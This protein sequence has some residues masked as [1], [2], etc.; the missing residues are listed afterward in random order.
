MLRR[1]FNESTSRRVSPTGCGRKGAR[2]YSSPSASDLMKDP[3][4][5]PKL[6]TILFGKIMLLRIFFGNALLI[7][8]IFGFRHMDGAA[9]CKVRDDGYMDGGAQKSQYFL[10][11]TSLGGNSW[12]WGGWR[13]TLF[14][15][16]LQIRGPD[17]A[18]T[19]AHVVTM[20]VM[21]AQRRFKSGEGHG[22][23]VTSMQ[24][25]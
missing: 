20:E 8:Y 21:H 23:R 13:R 25:C 6:L 10:C 18:C 3:A 17:A 19:E 12:F 5:G 24:I 11:S 4:G 1:H 15:Q 2:F 22:K 7:S 14:R 16:P 9:C